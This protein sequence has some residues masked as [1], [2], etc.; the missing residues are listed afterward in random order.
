MM[1]MIWINKSKT[2]SIF[3]IVNWSTHE[4]HVLDGS[5]KFD[6]Q[7][8]WTF[9]KVHIRPAKACGYTDWSVG[10]NSSLKKY[11]TLFLS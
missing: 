7:N 2:T 10:L 4:T 11:L 3:L 1:K 5:N 9:S 8:K 6:P